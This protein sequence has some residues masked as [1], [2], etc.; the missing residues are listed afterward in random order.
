MPISKTKLLFNLVHSLDKSEK[1][2]FKLFANRLSS[3]K[4]VHFIKLFEVLEKMNPLNQDK[5]LMAFPGM[6]R[7][8][9]NNLK[10]HLYSQIMK[11]L[12]LLHTNK[13]IEIQL[14]E[15]L[16]FAQILYGKGL[17]LQS[18]KLLDR[19]T[20]IAKEASKNLLYFEVLEFQKRIESR[21]ITRSR[22]VKNKV[23]N[24]INKSNTLKEIVAGTSAFLNLS[25]RVQG[26]YIKLGFAK[27]ERDLFIINEYFQSNLPPFDIRK[28]SFYE[29]I[30][31][32]QSYVWYN[33]MT[34]NFKFAYKH[35]L[36]W[37][38]HFNTSPIMKQKDPHL[39]LRGLHY[40]M[41][42]AYYFGSLDKF[43]RSYYIMISFHRKHGDSF[44]ENTK[45]QYFY[46]LSIAEI[47][48]I[49]LEGD[50]L[51]GTKLV[52]SVLSNLSQH[53]QKMDLHKSYIFYYKIAWVYF[54]AG[55][56]SIA[57]DYLNKLIYEEGNY[58]RQDVIVYAKLLLL[59][60]H[61]HLRNYDLISNTI[62]NVKRSFSKQAEQSKTV[63]L[64]LELLRKSA[65]AK[66]FPSKTELENVLNQLKQLRKERLER[67]AF[68][69]FAFDLW[70]ESL[71]QKKSSLETFQNTGS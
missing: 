36:Q 14:R 67:R 64:I 4:D 65:K 19:I 49:Y 66:L 69:Y 43:L 25:L 47:N 27:S 34:L 11:S 1:R 56:Y 46:Y 58:L 40:A 6:N 15:Q 8:N 7:T 9:F 30:F 12:R 59:I 29:Y 55:K 31:L 61:F 51:Q 10:R 48:R 28:L 70:I 41:T 45:T 5:L 16:D 13:N 33:Y 39:Y 54:G 17:Y 50:Y 60:S 35:A 26:L 20:P 42:S 32:H 53:S 57:I 52:P 24:L 3:N 63:D 71:I 38:D 68:L 21:H 2:N 18:L 44:S 22:K 62:L 37:V 23:E